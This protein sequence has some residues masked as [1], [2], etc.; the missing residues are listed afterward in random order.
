MLVQVMT[1]RPP[2]VRRL[3]SRLTFGVTALALASGSMSSHRTVQV[4][5]RFSGRVVER[6]DFFRGEHA[7]VGEC[8]AVQVG[9]HFSG[10]VGA[11]RPS[12]D[13]PDFF[14]RTAPGVAWSDFGACPV[15]PDVLQGQ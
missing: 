6:A 3:S 2:G 9:P 13:A 15:C 11:A 7:R 12:G 4:T 14:L 8:R 5:P 1:F 10:E